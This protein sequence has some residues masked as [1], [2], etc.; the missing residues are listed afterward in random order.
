MIMYGGIGLVALIAVVFIGY[1]L[2]KEPEQPAKPITE[3]VKPV[4]VQ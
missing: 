2:T 1:Q 4:V 3:P